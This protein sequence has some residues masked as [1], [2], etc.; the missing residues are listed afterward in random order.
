MPMHATPAAG[1]FGFTGGVLYVSKA[2]IAA[3]FAR[4][5]A[6]ARVTLYEEFAEWDRTLKK[7]SA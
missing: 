2:R 5:V 7:L 4:R 3:D 6:L 1:A